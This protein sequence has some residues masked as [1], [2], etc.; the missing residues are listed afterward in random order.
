VV[1]REGA[2][3]CSCI[4]PWPDS[5]SPSSSSAPVP[6]YRSRW[7]S[8]WT[9]GSGPHGSRQVSVGGLRPRH[10]RRDA[11]ENREGKGT[12][13]QRRRTD[14]PSND[15]TQRGAIRTRFR[16]APPVLRGW[17]G[18]H[19]FGRTFTGTT[20]TGPSADLIRF[21]VSGVGSRRSARTTRPAGSGRRR[22]K[23]PVSR[24][25]RVV[26][27]GQSSLQLTTAFAVFSKLQLT[28]VSPAEPRI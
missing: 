22:R 9:G 19:R 18:C 7:E 16:L 17:G 14:I 12:T 13:I 15:V 25:F 23:R 27:A 11:G 4:V 2:G 6:G 20:R 1:V 21:A 3:R 10:V 5:R 28:R 24:L 26:P 8:G